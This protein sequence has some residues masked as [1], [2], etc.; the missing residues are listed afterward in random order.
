MYETNLDKKPITKNFKIG[1]I[2]AHLTKNEL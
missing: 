1:P 2:F